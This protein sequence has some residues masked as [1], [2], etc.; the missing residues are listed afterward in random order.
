MPAKKSRS[1]GKS[2]KVRKVRKAVKKP[3]AKP[4]K[5]R[6]TQKFVELSELLTSLPEGK[7]GLDGHDPVEQLA[8]VSEAID[9]GYNPEGLCSAHDP[10]DIVCESLQEITYFGPWPG[11]HSYLWS[12]YDEGDC[13]VIWRPSLLRLPVLEGTSVIDYIGS[14]LVRGPRGRSS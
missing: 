9:N 10:V 7:P 12:M 2:S 8:C 5:P 3:A 4:R 11:G 6:R 14:P 13:P 1:R